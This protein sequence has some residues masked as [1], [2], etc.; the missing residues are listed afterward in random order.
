[1]QPYFGL[2]TSLYSSLDDCSIE[3]L[4]TAI[5]L[6]D[7]GAYDEAQRIFDGDLLP[8]KMLPVVVLGRAELEF[9][10]YKVGRV[11]RTLDKAL[12]HAS[13]RGADLERAEFR[14][15]SLTRAF[16]AFSHEGDYKPAL[17]EIHKA[18]AWLK[19]V[20]VTDYTD[21][22]VSVPPPTSEY[23]NSSICW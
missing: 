18:H 7:R 22:Q 20:P 23:E 3:R 19:D 21:I 12:T 14:L 17:E 11:F 8:L 2:N 15:M 4:E 13:K 9:K 16:A 6:T 5:V 1:M 10:Q